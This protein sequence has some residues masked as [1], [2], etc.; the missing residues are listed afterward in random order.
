MAFYYDYGAT[1][2]Y[3]SI[4][5]ILDFISM[6]LLWIICTYVLNKI[7]AIE[8]DLNPEK[9]GSIFELNF[10]KKW[11]SSCDEAQKLI[12]Y[13]AAYKAYKISNVSCMILWCAAFVLM[14]IEPGFL[15]AVIFVTIIMIVNNISFMVAGAKYERNNK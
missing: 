2:T 12:M 1:S 5:I 6:I 3:H 8:K 13:K 14:L 4:I 11:L 7:V 9:E 10:N 15:F